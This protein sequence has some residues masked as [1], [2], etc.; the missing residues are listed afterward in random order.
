MKFSVL[1]LKFISSAAHIYRFRLMAPNWGVTMI[2][3][4]ELAQAVEIHSEC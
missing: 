3:I 4:K 2:N 1:I